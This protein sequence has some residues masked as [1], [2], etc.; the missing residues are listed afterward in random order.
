MPPGRLVI[1]RVALHAVYVHGRRFQCVES[2]VTFNMST[3]SYR[4]INLP[5]HC[6]DFIM[7]GRRRAGAMNPGQ[8]HWIYHKGEM[9]LVPMGEAWIYIK[10]TDDLN[11]IIHKFVRKL[12]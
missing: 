4:K 8:T 5:D 7:F 9:C 1:A 6:V 10:G 3:A 12:D 11:F 2:S